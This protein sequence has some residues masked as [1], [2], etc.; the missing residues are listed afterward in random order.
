MP[1]AHD[2]PLHGIRVLETS[3]WV[4]GPFA[5]MALADLGADVVKVERPGRGDLHRTFGLRRDGVGALWINVNRG[6]RSVA[7]DLKDPGDRSRFMTLVKAADVLVQNWRPSVAQRLGLDD[8]VLAQ[9]NPRLIRVAI[10]GF[11][12]SGPRSDERHSTA[13]FRALAGLRMPKGN[14]AFHGPWRAWSW[15]KPAQWPSL[16]VYWPRW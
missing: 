1:T 9:A 2:A 14:G 16:R 12:T 10:T 8:D 13:S 5:T 6:K 4:S 3:E 15:T 11:G 7:L